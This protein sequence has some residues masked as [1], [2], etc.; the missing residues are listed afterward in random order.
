MLSFVPTIGNC[1]KADRS[2]ADR[3][4]VLPTTDEPEDR[5]EEEE[6]REQREKAV[7]GEESRQLPTPIVSEFLDHR[8]DKSGWPPALLQ[9]V[10]APDDPLNRVHGSS[11]FRRPVL[12]ILVG[13]R[14]RFRRV[15]G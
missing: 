7:E 10:C 8:E 15:S 14:P 13:I 1:E 5:H 6:E 9:P 3:Q 11:P 4:R 2:T 12:E